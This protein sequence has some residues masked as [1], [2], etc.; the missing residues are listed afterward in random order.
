M[1]AV[2]ASLGRAAIIDWTTGLLGAVS[3]LLLI[4]YRVRSTWLV[5]GGAVA[6]IA[7]RALGVGP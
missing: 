2:T 7:L 3:A 1:V 4:R 6:G 5:L